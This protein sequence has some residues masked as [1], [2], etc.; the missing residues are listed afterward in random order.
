MAIFTPGPTVAA[1][2]GSI[3]GTVFSRNK[4]G[5]YIR[6]RAIPLTVTS[7]KALKYKSVLALISQAWAGVTAAN[8]KAW[9]IYA[10]QN[11]VVNALG[12]SKALTAANH[13][14]RLNT[15]LTVA[16]DAAILVPPV[17]AAPTGIVAV[18][19]AV[20]T[21][22]AED[23]ELVFTDT[24]LAA[25]E[26]LWIRGCKVSSA[27]INNVENLLT[28]VLITAKAATS[29]VDLS[30]ALVTAFGALQAGAVY[31]LECRVFDTTT[32]LMS[33]RVFIRTTAITT[34]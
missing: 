23:T 13:F 32:G 1:V 6:N 25:G 28:E 4:G 7:E 12:Q 19:F 20:D 31:V 17:T 26:R 8:R 11:T 2:S 3:G 33:N 18:S 10:Q 21:N 9:E 24:P 14:V 5:A 22:P 27:A 30:A 34:P 16:G 29:P 15:R